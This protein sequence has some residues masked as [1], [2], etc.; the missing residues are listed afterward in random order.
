MPLTVTSRNWI[1]VASNADLSQKMDRRPVFPSRIVVT[2]VNAIVRM[3]SRAKR[4][5]KD[6]VPEEGTRP[7]P[8][9]LHKFRERRERGSLRCYTS[10]NDGL[11]V[12][13]S[14]G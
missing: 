12:R 8:S 14:R 4:P 10:G 3:F 2:I 5:K 6:V 11:L 13:N 1:D 9:V 7:V